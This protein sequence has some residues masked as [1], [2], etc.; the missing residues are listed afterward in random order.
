MITPLMHI[1]SCFNEDY[2]IENPVDVLYLNRKDW[3][4][5]VTEAKRLCSLVTDEDALFS[6]DSPTGYTMIS[7]TQ[8]IAGT[9]TNLCPY[10]ALLLT[11]LKSCVP[12]YLRE[13]NTVSIEEAEDDLST[14]AV[15][16]RLEGNPRYI[17]YY[18]YSVMEMSSMSYDAKISKLKEL[19]NTVRS[20]VLTQTAI[21]G[22]EDA[23]PQQKK[24]LQ[25]LEMQSKF[26]Y[27]KGMLLQ[28]Y[29]MYY[30]S[31][32]PEFTRD[33]MKTIKRELWDLGFY[34]FVNSFQMF[35]SFTGSR[36]T[37]KRDVDIDEWVITFLT[38][39]VLSGGA[40]L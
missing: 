7:P 16:L 1:L 6:I 33:T 19:L 40:T 27:W 24:L 31:V 28:D 23:N 25:R 13:V 21:F 29:I 36:V 14:D 18:V 30:G 15:V 8:S 17:Y 22:G 4:L 26:N 37:R 11:R 35:L 2:A 9:A 10:T 20:H 5:I 39:I 34:G 38:K 3:E 12:V 32:P